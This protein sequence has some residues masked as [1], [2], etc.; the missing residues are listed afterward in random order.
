MTVAEA[1]TACQERALV[2]DLLTGDIGRLA[3]LAWCPLGETLT[4]SLRHFDPTAEADG[5]YYVHIDVLD[6]ERVEH[7]ELSR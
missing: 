2:R 3:A 5:G 1:F 6:L 7:Y 4:A